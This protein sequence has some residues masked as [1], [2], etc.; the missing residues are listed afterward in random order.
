MRY[1]PLR[2]RVRTL[3]GCTV[4]L[5][6]P[7]VL[8]TVP[9]IVLFGFG[10][11]PIRYLSWPKH[12]QDKFEPDLETRLAPAEAL[13]HRAPQVYFSRPNLQ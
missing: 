4:A 10:L 1:N 5:H 3:A 13:G 2:K 8:V 9:T 6:T 11:L 12:R 7:L